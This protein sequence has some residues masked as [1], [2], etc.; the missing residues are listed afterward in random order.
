M[1][2]A[3]TEGRDQLVRYDVAT[4]TRTPASEAEYQA[5][6]RAAASPVLIVGSAESR[7]PAVSFTVVNSQ[8]AVDTRSE[9]PGPAFVAATGEHLRVSVPDRYDGVTL[10]VFQRLDDDRFALVAEG[11]VK[12]APIGDLLVCGIS[13]GKC[14]TIATGEEYWLLPGISS[15]GAED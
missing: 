10:H 9:N 15:V 11:G 13:A 5:E 12:R 3:T 8:L 4:G 6:T 14:H 2:T 7:D 1:D